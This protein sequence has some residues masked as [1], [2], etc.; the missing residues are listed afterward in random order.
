M[1]AGFLQL[2]AVGAENEWLTFNPQITFFKT[3]FLRHTN[4]SSIPYKLNFNN[5][6]NFNA[7]GTCIISP[8]GD[9]LHDM[10]LVINLPGI[11]IKY[12]PL[13]W[14]LIN[15]ILSD[16]NIVY[17]YNVDNVI[18]LQE[19]QEISIDINNAIKN[20][21]NELKL[22][23]ST[24]STIQN[25]STNIQNDFYGIIQYLNLGNNVSFINDC[26][27]N[28][29]LDQK[30]YGIHDIF[31]LYCNNLE[32]MI[33]F[34]ENSFIN[35]ELQFYNSIVDI[36]KIKTLNNCYSKTKID[37]CISNNKKDI[38]KELQELIK[39][40]FECTIKLFDIIKNKKFR[41]YFDENVKTD[42]DLPNFFYFKHNINI[43]LN[44]YIPMLNISN[45]NIPNLNSIPMMVIVDIKK[46]INE[47]FGIDI[48]DTDF[49]ENLV[50]IDIDNKM[51]YFDNKTI[52]GLCVIE[53][54]INSYIKYFS[55][56]ANLINEKLGKGSYEKLIELI[57]TYK[58][59]NNDENDNKS[60]NICKISVLYLELY[61]EF[62]KEYNY[63]LNLVFDK[64]D[65]FNYI[66]YR[67]DDVYFN[68]IDNYNVEELFKEYCVAMKNYCNMN[69]LLLFKKSY[70]KFDF[71]KNY[72]IN[73]I[74]YEFENEI[75]NNKY[76]Y[77]PNCDKAVVDD[78]LK[79]NKNFIENSN[80]V[81]IKS[82]CGNNND[83]IQ[84]MNKYT[85]DCD[86]IGQLLDASLKR[87]INDTEYSQ[88]V[89]NYSYNLLIEIIN[90]KIN[91]INNKLNN[92]GTTTFSGSKLDIR[93]KNL[94][95]GKPKFAWEKGIGLQLIKK[96]SI[97]F[98]DQL[99]DRH[100]GKSMIFHSIATND[101]DKDSGYFKMI[102]N[103]PELYDYNSIQTIHILYMYHYNFFL[104]DIHHASLP[105][106]ALL[107]TEVIIELN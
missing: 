80:I 29:N 33:L 91:D 77:Y 59:F 31:H 75:N 48:D 28:I 6:V 83:M 41:I 12:P 27:K 15:S 11:N 23:E 40:D 9:L 104:I 102:G 24:L 32:K 46:N 13:T 16:Y 89:N 5:D 56:N 78:I 105:L 95:S 97:Y 99:I 92:I 90:K 76:V 73:D 84:I 2:V 17:S 74:I 37:K 69:S 63:Y 3:V 8:R 64:Y 19:Y 57:N 103:I 60:S 25:L 65:L 21:T 35:D 79:K 47:E 1:T 50:N 106:V 58:N 82:I 101:V 43:L 34:H 49:Y 26:S 70:D 93:L 45:S 4:F 98:G 10:Y 107:N 81:N 96:I 39:K 85:N 94:L 20:Y 51:S 61:R 87:I 62:I 54:V 30:I 52:D 88:L 100:T 36:G 38:I 42:Y 72:S 55:S 18:T 86:N 67:N 22:V 66:C 68:G 53:Y 7:I 14:S 71:I 44:K